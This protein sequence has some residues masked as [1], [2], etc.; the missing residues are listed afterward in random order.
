MPDITAI[1][2]LIISVGVLVVS[3]GIFYLVVKLGRA[4]ESLV[5]YDS[6]RLGRFDRS[7]KSNKREDD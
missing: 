2:A 5:D 6:S 7:D 3:V 1:S 4:I